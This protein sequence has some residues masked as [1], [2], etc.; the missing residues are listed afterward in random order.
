MLRDGAARDMRPAF[1]QLCLS[2][3]YLV[4][5]ILGCSGPVVVSLFGEVYH[6]LWCDPAESLIEGD[7]EPCG[8]DLNP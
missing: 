2:I 6:V 3:P 7:P 4:L 5:T 8:E 1:Q